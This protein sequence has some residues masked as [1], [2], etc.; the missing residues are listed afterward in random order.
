MIRNRPVGAE[1]V[2]LRDSGDSGDAGLTAV[3]AAAIVAWD[4][5][6][7]PSSPGNYFHNKH[8]GLRLSADFYL[9]QNHVYLWSPLNPW[10]NVTQPWVQGYDGDFY[11]GVWN[12]NAVHARLWIDQALKAEMGS[13]FPYLW[14]VLEGV[15]RARVS[16]P[17]PFSLGGEIRYLP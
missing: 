11:M 7:C 1:G 6:R 4:R 17:A 2:L 3:G 5:D 10:F 9:V 8:L 15:G 16:F 12:K 13:Q 14:L